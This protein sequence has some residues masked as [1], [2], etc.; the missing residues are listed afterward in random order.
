MSSRYDTESD[1]VLFSSG[2]R[3]TRCALQALGFDDITDSVVL[4]AQKMANLQV[5]EVEYAILSSVCLCSG[6]ELSC[7]LLKADM[8]CDQRGNY[9]STI[10]IHP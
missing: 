9:K 8:S 2:L 3:L 10:C 7:V 1:S 6:G 5:D 4:F